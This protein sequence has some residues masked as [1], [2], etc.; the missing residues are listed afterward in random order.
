ML[1]SCRTGGADNR[2][3]PQTLP[4]AWL[5]D[6]AGGI[7]LIRCLA[8][9]TGRRSRR[10]SLS[11][12]V[13]WATSLGLPSHADAVADPI[14]LLVGEC[15]PA[16]GSGVYLLLADAPTLKTLSSTHAPWLNG[17]WV[18]WVAEFRVNLALALLIGGPLVLRLTFEGFILPFRINA[19]L[20]E[21]RR[22]LLAQ[23]QKA[24]GTTTV[25]HAAPPPRCAPP[26]GRGQLSLGGP[27]VALERRG[28][29]I[30]LTA[31]VRRRNRRW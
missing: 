5:T 30:W 23:N 16:F 13:S 14:D 29:R 12:G 9:A 2:Q 6:P 8:S 15:W 28:Q 27:V 1:T 21:I 22:A 25:S 7:I 20:T 10:F 18:D 17:A 19:T 26:M 4:L 3:C 31:A 24:A 11:R